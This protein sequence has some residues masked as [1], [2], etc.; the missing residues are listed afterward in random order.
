MISSPM[1]KAVRAVLF[2]PLY[3]IKYQ[4]S[5]Q[6][7]S[8]S[9]KVKAVTAIH[10]PNGLRFFNA[11]YAVRKKKG[12]SAFRTSTDRALAVPGPK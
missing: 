8:H 6:I 2:G 1:T 4:E 12:V 11:K 9:A 10:R 5:A 3:T 7:R